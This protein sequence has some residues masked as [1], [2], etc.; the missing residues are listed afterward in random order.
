MKMENKQIVFV[1]EKQ[2]NEEAIK[3]I[4]KQYGLFA[5]SP[6]VSATI[7]DLSIQ[8]EGKTLFPCVLEAK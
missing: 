1:E 8:R 4:V 2:M 6:N 7:Y 3:E 5:V